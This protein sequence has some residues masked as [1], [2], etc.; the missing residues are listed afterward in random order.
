MEIYLDNAATTFPKPEAVYRA[1]ETYMRQ[2]GASA[3]RGHYRKALEAEE[4]VYK[5]RAALG[6]LFGIDNAAQIIFTNNVTDSLNLALKG[7][8]E[9]GDHVITSNIE[10]NSMWRPL[11]KLEQDQNISISELVVNPD[12]SFDAGQIEN[13][14]TKK[15]KLFCLLH[16][17]NVLGSILPIPKI[18]EIAHAYNIPVLID[19]AQTA[20]VYPIDVSKEGIDLLAFTG[21]KGL[22]GPMG[23]G[24]LYIRE[25]IELKT[26]KEGGTGSNSSQEFQP[27]NLPDRYEVG[28]SNIWGLVGLKAAVEFIEQQGIEKIRAKEEMLTH[29]LLEIL[30]ALPGVNVYGSLQA[31]ER[32]GLVS[33]NLKEMVPEEVAFSLDESFGIMVRAGLHCSSKAHRLLGTEKRGAIR[34][35]VSYFNQ[36]E[37]IEMLGEAIKNIQ[38]K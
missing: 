1:V 12:G 16:A 27:Q 15:T 24:G 13:K 34:A 28:T 29:K 2:N 23:T 26:L 30:Q 3:G 7:I 4:L 33:F 6:R 8:L 5:T 21:H 19:A 31:H 38:A 22:L 35:S 20:G 11:K 37:D 17:S 36:V 9:P 25:G 14:I 32:V 10:H 18:T